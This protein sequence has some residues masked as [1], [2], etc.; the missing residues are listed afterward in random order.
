MSLGSPIHSLGRGWL[1]QPAQTPSM[2]TSPTFKSAI[3]PAHQSLCNVDSEQHLGKGRESSITLLL[4]PNRIQIGP[5]KR[6]FI[7]PEM[8]GFIVKVVRSTEKHIRNNPNSNIDTDAG[9]VS[10]DVVYNQTTTCPLVIVSFDF[11]SI[12]FYF[13]FSR[14]TAPTSSHARVYISFIRRHRAR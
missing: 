3:P 6:A 11:N 4:E 9:G 14:S 5:C 8:H 7:A 10:D 1:S 12:Q 2:T 13:S